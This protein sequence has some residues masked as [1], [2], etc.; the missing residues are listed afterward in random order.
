MSEFKRPAE[1]RRGSPATQATSTW[2]HAT[3]P[4]DYQVIEGRCAVE[5]WCR[6]V[7]CDDTSSLVEIMFDA[8]CRCTHVGDLADICLDGGGLSS[9]GTHIVLALCYPRRSEGRGISGRQKNSSASQMQNRNTFAV[10]EGL[11]PNK[12][13]LRS[14]EQRATSP[15]IKHK[16]G[17]FVGGQKPSAGGTRSQSRLK[18]T[19]SSGGF[20]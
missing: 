12:I 1:K 6:I 4:V 5:L 19:A 18:A 9:G 15:D 10:A 2:F 17:E 20:L 3:I 8:W 14:P 7:T 16:S 13:G 11:K